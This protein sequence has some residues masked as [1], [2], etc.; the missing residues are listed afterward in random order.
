MKDTKGNQLAVADEYLLMS[1]TP[2]NRTAEAELWSSM[3]TCTSAVFDSRSQTCACSFSLLQDCLL[4]RQ[5]WVAWQSC[6]H[7]SA[8]YSEQL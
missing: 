3:L 8:K 2:A 1:D 5:A 7:H 4:H 6:F